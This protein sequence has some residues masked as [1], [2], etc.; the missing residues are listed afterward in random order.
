[1]NEK[2]V[3]VKEYLDAF[4]DDGNSI[5]DIEWA[6]QFAKEQ[7]DQYKIKDVCVEYIYTNDRK[8]Y[9]RFVGQRPETDYERCKRLGIETEQDKANRIE[10]ERRERAE[11]ERLKRKFEVS[12]D[13]SSKTRMD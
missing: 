1:M 8:N 7:I 10:K 3:Y 5:A 6:I 11:Y 2:T 12:G 9:F 13:G 4:I